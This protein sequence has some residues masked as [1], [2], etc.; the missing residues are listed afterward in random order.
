MIFP[1]Y[2]QSSSQLTG[3][4]PA[5]AVGE[6]KWA[7]RNMGPCHTLKTPLIVSCLRTFTHSHTQTNWGGYPEIIGTYM[8]CQS[9]CQS[10]K[11]CPPLVLLTDL[12]RNRKNT[13]G[14]G[15]T[16]SDQIPKVNTNNRGG[17]ICIKCLPHPRLDLF[18]PFI[19]AE[20]EKRIQR[21]SVLVYLC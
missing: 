17:C 8:R 21:M 20:V 11:S 3:V 7:N 13:K 5:V 12:L 14:P 6:L 4:N 16:L 18:W 1:E 15:G 19:E 2:V 10:F 9:D